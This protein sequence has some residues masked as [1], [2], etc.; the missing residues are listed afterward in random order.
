[1]ERLKHWRKID[2]GRIKKGEDEKW[3]Q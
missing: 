2:T 3:E 1:M